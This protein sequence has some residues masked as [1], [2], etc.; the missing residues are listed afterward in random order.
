MQQSFR[1]A[2]LEQAVGISQAPASARNKKILDSSPLAV[3]KSVRR[4]PTATLSPCG[5]EA[6]AGL[7]A[8]EAVSRPRLGGN[9]KKQA[10]ARG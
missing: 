5:A 3:D 9:A 2:R 8:N 4:L 6:E 10:L 7:H 1:W